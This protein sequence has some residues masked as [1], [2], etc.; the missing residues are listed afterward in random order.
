[1]NSQEN[2][3]SY[4]NHEF[5]S[6]KSFMLVLDLI[7]KKISED[8]GKETNGE[9]NNII[10][11]LDVKIFISALSFELIIKLFYLLDKN[12]VHEKTH[13]IEKLF[14]ELNSES[15]E[16]I[17]EEFSKAVIKLAKNTENRIGSKLYIPDLRE[18]LSQNKKII[19]D[20]KYYSKLENG[21]IVTTNFLMNLFRELEKRKE[22]CKNNN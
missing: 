16:L 13:D 10:G 19:T 2:I 11:Y 5:F 14:D 6:L 20:F 1:M 3:E 8:I 17:E 7:E 18:A 12:K 21:S 4:I 15:K 9:N 22:T